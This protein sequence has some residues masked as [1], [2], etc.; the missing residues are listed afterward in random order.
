MKYDT[1]LAKA[2]KY[3]TCKY[4]YYVS[5]WAAERSGGMHIKSSTLGIKRQGVKGQR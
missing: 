1:V 3:T 4:V 5:M 2:N